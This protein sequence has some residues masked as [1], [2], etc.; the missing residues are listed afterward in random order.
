MTSSSVPAL[1]GHRQFGG[2]LADL[3]ED[4]VQPLIEQGGDIGRLGRVLPPLLDDPVNRFENVL[5]S[6][7]HAEYLFYLSKN[8]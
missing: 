7:I 3:G 1:A 8:L 5:L 6:I 2:L 4:L